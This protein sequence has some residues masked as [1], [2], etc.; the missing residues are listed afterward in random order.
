MVYVVVSWSNWPF[1]AE[2]SAIQVL[3]HGILDSC[4]I[5]IPDIVAVHW[6]IKDSTTTHKANSVLQLLHDTFV[7]GLCLTIIQ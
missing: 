4:F 5:H 6:F 7:K 1:F 2:D 3:Y